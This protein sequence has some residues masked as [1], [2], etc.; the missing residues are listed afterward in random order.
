M[1]WWNGLSNTQKQIVALI[2]AF[3]FGTT[4][5]GSAAAAV[6]LPDRMDVVEQEQRV[7][8]EEHTEILSEVE[9]LA[10]SVNRLTCIITARETGQ[11]I[12]PC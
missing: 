10:N 7:L 9:S 12:V 4:V 3:V 5:G 1:K 8:Q 6:T 11:S 2:A